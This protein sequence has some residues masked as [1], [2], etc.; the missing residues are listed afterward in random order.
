M[1]PLQKGLSQ[2]RQ[3]RKEDIYYEE[4]LCGLCA[5]ARNFWLFSVDS[6]MQEAVETRR[7]GLI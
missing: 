6:F 7:P 5:F 4:T 1:T 2:S 3:G